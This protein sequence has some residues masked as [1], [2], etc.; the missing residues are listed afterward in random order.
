MVLDWQLALMRESPIEKRFQRYLAGMDG[1]ETAAIGLSGESHF[2][3]YHQPGMTAKSVLTSAAER[4]LDG[5]LDQDEWD[6]LICDR[7]ASPRHEDRVWPVGQD[8]CFAHRFASRAPT[9]ARALAIL[10]GHVQQQTE[11]CTKSRVL[12]IGGPLAR[13]HGTEFPVVQGPMTRVSDVSEFCETVAR[14]GGLPF[15]AL[16]LMRGEEV[17]EKLGRTRDLMG[18][19]P[20]GV[21]ILGFALRELQEEQMPV[22]REIRR[23]FAIIAGGR[24][25][26]AASLESDG[27]TAYLHVPS[28]GMLKAFILE[29]ARRIASKGVAREA[30][31]EAGQGPCIEVAE[32][33]QRRDGM[34][35]LGQL[36]ALRDGETT[37]R[38]LHENVCSGT[39]WTPWRE[40]SPS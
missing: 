3:I 28:P 40:K 12:G 4:F 31:A 38:D 7:L 6:K 26:Q 1:S 17:R 36:A 23:P 14:G 29:G 18:D 21:G 16:G 2:R 20:W 35:M 9:V 27:I 25:D 34:Y 8:A 30:D 37:I 24:P 15:L 10:R 33:D 32:A 5:E 19:Q 22:I 11:A 13:S 39:A